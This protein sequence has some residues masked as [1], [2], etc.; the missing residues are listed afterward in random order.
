MSKT[1]REAPFRKNEVLHFTV[2]DL[3]THGEGIGHP[4]GYTV[5]VEG[6]LP[7][8]EIE[9]QLIKTTSGYGVGKLLRIL[10]PSEDR[11]EPDCPLAGRCGGCQLQH[12]SYTGQL[13]YKSAKIRDC[14]NRIGHF[15]LE[16]PVEILGDEEG[17]FHYRN[18]AQFPVQELDGRPEAGLY[19]AR[20][21]RLLPCYRCGLQKD[22]ANRLLEKIIRFAP[23]A[24]LSAYDENTRKGLLRHV[25]IRTSANGENSVTLVLNS[26]RLPNAEAWVRRMKELSVTS[27][28]VNF[29]TED[30]NVILGR[31]TK[32][33]FGS[34][35][36]TDH[37]G[38]LAFQ[39]SPAS[40]FQVNG[41]QTEVLYGKALEFA[42]LT[43]RETVIDAYCG[44]GT[45]SLFLARRAAFVYGIE[46]VHAAVENARQNAIL[47][48]CG[49]TEFRLGPSEELIPRRVREEGVRPD[50]CVV[51]PPRAGCEKELLDALCE[52]GCG[53]LVYVSCDPAT[54]A[55]DLDYLFHEKRAFSLEKV[56]GVDM[57]PN[58]IHVETVCLL[59]KLNAKQHIEINL[60]MDEL[61]LT[62]AEKKAAY[63]EIKDY[64][65]YISGLKVSSLYIEQVK[66]RCGIIERENYN[67]PKSE[68]AKQPQCPPDKEKAIKEALQ[69]F[70]MN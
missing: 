64:V 56:C 44:I 22:E 54:L 61:D 66:Q 39:I 35:T 16:E 5:F 33:L 43:G 50:V 19:A 59:S 55:R 36:I 20:S 49:N 41:R 58:T 8:E 30:S 34:E 42:A 10:V 28:A 31:E 14:L 65:R 21:H 69:H 46:I 24:G 26:R 57:F 2:D 12:L 4:E 23:S 17:R 45:I 48:A 6:A 60:D 38:E 62:D 25:L 47:N 67:K 7:G 32:I 52:S 11:V 9:A 27:F 40:F 18:K 37:I 51:D 63:Q 70:G 15:S 29:N 3:G 1:D 13:R 53:R 68:D